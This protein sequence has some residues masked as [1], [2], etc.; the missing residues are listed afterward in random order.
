[1]GILEDIQAILHGDQVTLN[2]DVDIYADTENNFIPKTKVNM[3]YI[4]MVV[5]FDDKKNVLLI[6]EAKKS[7]RG[8]WYLPAGRLEPGETIMDGAKREVK[9]ESGFDCDLTTLISVEVSSHTWMRFTFTGKITG[10][11]LKTPEQQDEESIQ[12]KFFSNEEFQASIGI[13]RHGD[14][15]KV[16][17][18]AKKYWDSEITHRIPCT[19]P[20]ICPHK[21]LINRV[22]VID[23]ANTN[24]IAMNILANKKSGLHIPTALINH[25]KGSSIA[26]SVYA[27]LREAFT[28]NPSSASI[29]MCGILGVEH[30]GTG[31][32][33]SEDGICITTLVSLDLSDQVSPPTVTSENY[34]W[35]P[36]DVKDVQVHLANCAKGKIIP[37]L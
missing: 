12:A 16:V 20:V 24:T 9:E 13:L 21:L 33:K 36:V 31:T 25:S 34:K 22:V 4:C 37:L 3:C 19:L 15:L 2:K 5:L 28:T 7:C 35:C 10:G 14:I 6:Q 26:I 32:G 11:K 27:I 30:R 18:L 1:M 23:R 29:R 17:E 8:T